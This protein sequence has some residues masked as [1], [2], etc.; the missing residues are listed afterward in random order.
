MPS[1]SIGQCQIQ[2]EVSRSVAASERRITVT[3][4]HVNVRAL[5]SDDDSQIAE[6]LHR[7]R[8][9][10]FNAVRDMEKA[11]SGRASVPRFMSGSRIPYR[12]RTVRLTVR[13]HDGDHVE[14][15]FDNGVVVDLPHWVTNREQE[16]IV[17]TE[18]KLWLK[19]KVRRDVARIV[20]SFQRRHGIKPKA[21]RV[22][23]MKHGWGACG[24]S[25]VLLINWELIFAPLAVLEYVVAHELAHLKVR[26]HKPEFWHY[27]GQLM[28][29][30]EQPKSWLNANQGVL[31]AAFLKLS[32]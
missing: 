27:L 20:G 5:E 2:Y 1:I 17:A 30:Y 10:L 13:R 18:I 8:Q 4:G 3:P 14:T 19:Q 24:P 29:D 21:V 28:P 11:T 22:A 7:K 12:G 23:E 32:A 15:S 26:T 25:G 16:R 9:W 31:S 6:F